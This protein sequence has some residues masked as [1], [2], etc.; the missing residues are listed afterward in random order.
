VPNVKAR[1]SRL[2]DAMDQHAVAVTL[3][4]L[5]RDVPVPRL[6]AV[7]RVT[8]MARGVQRIAETEVL[9]HVCCGPLCLECSRL[10]VRRMTQG[11]IE[12]RERGLPLVTPA[13][14]DG[15]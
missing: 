15:R 2:L 7:V 12:E 8:W 6:L 11:E 13:P 10:V 4:P 1:L 5:V 3:V 14:D 9:P